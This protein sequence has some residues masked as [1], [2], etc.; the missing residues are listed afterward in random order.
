MAQKRRKFSP[1]FR[2]E[3]VKMVVVESRPIA[4]VARVAYFIPIVAVK[5]DSTG[6]RNTLITEV[7]DGAR[8]EEDAEVACGC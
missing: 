3:A 5:A 8:R 2:D 1:E 7:R 4:E 6:R